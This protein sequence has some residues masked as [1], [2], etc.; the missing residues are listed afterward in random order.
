MGKTYGV[1][2]RYRLSAEEAEIAA[3]F[4]V[5]ISEDLSLPPGEL[6]PKRTGVVLRRDVEPLMLDAMSWGLP[7]P[8]SARSPITNVRNLDS[9][10]WRTLLARPANR[11]LVPVTS[12]CEWS[13]EK[14]AKVENW[15][16]LRDR[17][18]FA[19]AGV[20]RTYGDVA[21]RS[22]GFLT[23][24]PNPLVAPVHPKA[25]PVVLHAEDHDRW[26]DGTMDDVRDLASPFPSQLMQ[27]TTG[28]IAPDAAERA[29]RAENNV[30]IE[31]PAGN[32]ES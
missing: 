14:G 32:V 13:G 17:P 31:L 18:I 5:V 23:C 30:V 26:L 2:N 27:M 24:E 9:P 7:P 3:T 21:A 28:E 20:W 11:C 12:F 29:A 16:S 6:F 1:C 22:Y 10:F 15:F 25:M 8:A 4:G 19:F